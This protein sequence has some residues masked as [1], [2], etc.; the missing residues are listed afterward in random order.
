MS[1]SLC[2]QPLYSC[3]TVI[4]H[5]FIQRVIFIQHSFVQCMFFLLQILYISYSM[6][7]LNLA[8]FSTARFRRPKH[9][10]LSS[11]TQANCKGLL[12]SA[13]PFCDNSLH[14]FTHSYTYTC[15]TAIPFCD[16]SLHIFTHSN[17]V[18][19]LIHVALDSFVGPRHQSLSVTLQPSFS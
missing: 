4:L 5:D 16:I 14:I 15:Y 1:K 17:I 18:Y 19:K 8:Q 2:F 9:Q 6:I 3:P 7:L 10:S 11:V 13:V 12:C